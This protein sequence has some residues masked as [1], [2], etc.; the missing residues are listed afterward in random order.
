MAEKIFDT[1]SKLGGYAGKILAENTEKWGVDAFKRNPGIT[2]HFTGCK[3]RLPEPGS[4]ERHLMVWYNEFAGKLLCGLA[5]NYMSSPSEELLCAG[6]SLADALSDVQCPDGYLGIYGD[7]RKF[8]LDGENWD[9][10]G[11]YHSVYGL[12]LWYKA[13]SD[14]KALETAKKALDCVWNYF[15]GSGRTFDSAGNQTMNLAVSHAFAVMYRETGDKRYLEAAKRIVD[16]EWTMSGDWKRGILSGKEFYESPLPRWEALHTIMT[17]AELYEITGES[18]YFLTLEKIWKSIRKTDRHNTGG[19]SCGEAACGSPYRQGAI[20]TCCTVAWAALTTE[21]LKISDDPAAADELELSF[22]NGIL[23]SLTED[24]R[25]V[26]YSTPM[27]N[28]ISNYSS[29]VDI[30][31]QCNR[32]SPDLTCC[33]ANALRGLYEITRSAVISDADAVRINCYAPCEVKSKTP[34]GEELI[35]NV[36][37]DYPTD[38]NVKIALEKVGGAGGS[39]EIRLRVPAWSKKTIV[40]VNGK[41]LCGASAG[42]FFPIKREWKSGDVIELSL[43]MTPHFM[44]GKEDFDGALSV[45]RGPILMALDSENGK[46]AEACPDFAKPLPFSLSELLCARATPCGDGEHN[47]RFEIK[48]KDG[49]KT[50]LYDFASCGKRG[51][52]TSWLRFEGEAELEAEDAAENGADSPP[53]WCKRAREGQ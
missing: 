20:E 26:T 19:F 15:Y 16:E 47:I 17:L 51:G 8:G 24:A 37:S 49:S 10:W 25:L 21:Y 30:G 23:G 14:K 18:E 9:V 4:D 5:L 3:N 1:S 43:D 7:D 22:F 12:Y 48:N 11:H 42:S 29:V 41:A 27:Q 34:L 33:Q 50:V 31:F 35:L 40:A 45:Y 28:S 46:D 36:I 13:S 53:T 2:G 32:F 38:G 52:Y 39:F 6:N 44:L